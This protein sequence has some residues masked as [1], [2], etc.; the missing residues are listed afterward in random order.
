MDSLDERDRALVTRLVMGSVIAQGELDRVIDAHLRRAGH[1]EP[2]VRDALRIATFEVLYLATP[3]SAS[4]SQGV[5]LVRS[6]SSRA[7]GTCQRGAASR[8]RRGPAR[9]ARGAGAR[10]GRYR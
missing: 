8:R 10:G 3:T 2:R 9:A 5:E 4:V 7:A 6:V 1:L